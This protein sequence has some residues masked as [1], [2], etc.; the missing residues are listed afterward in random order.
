MASE[1]INSQG[2]QFQRGN[3]AAT[4]VFATVGEVKSFSGPSGSATADSRLS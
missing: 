3:G 2:I 1:A 4:E